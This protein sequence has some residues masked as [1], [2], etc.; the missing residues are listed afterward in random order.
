MSLFPFLSDPLTTNSCRPEGTTP[1][2]IPVGDDHADLIEMASSNETTGSHDDNVSLEK[3]VDGRS[4]KVTS[5]ND[6]P[7]L[8]PP[9]KKAK[10]LDSIE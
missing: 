10:V 2:N 9:S 6:G 5:F 4:E 7:D 1:S 3:V 8:P